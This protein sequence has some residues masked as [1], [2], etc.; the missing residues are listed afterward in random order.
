[1][2]YG[3]PCPEPIKKAGQAIE[4]A[5]RK[6]LDVTATAVYGAY[7]VSYQAVEGL[8]DMGPL[9]LL[10]P[11]EVQ[12]ET[13]LMNFE[14]LGLAGDALWDYMQ[15]GMIQ[16]E[17]GSGG[18]GKEGGFKQSLIPNTFQEWLGHDPNSSD[19]SWPCTYLPGIHDD[20]T[21]DLHW[22]ERLGPLLP[23]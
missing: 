16:T 7:F 6:T 15:D 12:L 22:L 5:G 21:V 23:F 19:C 11:G 1:V 20:G 17:G 10:I 2:G 13:A 9:R 14:V 18:R 3:A 4:G 8:Q